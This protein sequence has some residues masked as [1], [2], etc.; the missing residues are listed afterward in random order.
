MK[1]RDVK[2]GEI[3][4]IPLKD[5]DFISAKVLY[6]SAYFKDVIL[7]ALFP[8]KMSAERMPESLP[9]EPS[10]L[11]YTSQLSITKGRWKSVGVQGLRKN[12]IDKARRIVADEV[13]LNDEQLRSATDEDLAS[14]PKMSVCGADWV[15]EDA[16]EIAAKMN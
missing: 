9:N 2:T 10:L 14:L 8:H 7:L 1:K 11:L 4:L 3:A 5:G 13:W 15:E 12:E 16:E 6:L